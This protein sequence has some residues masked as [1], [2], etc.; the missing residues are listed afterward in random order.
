MATSP[1]PID[2]S[3]LNMST[4]SSI[5]G[6]ANSGF[7]AG[8]LAIT[9]DLYCL[10]YVVLPIIAGLIIVIAA[11]SIV[12]LKCDSEDLSEELP[13]ENAPTEAETA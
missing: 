13:N 2:Q 6:T 11:I 12:A 9:L 3:D 8:N 1:S 5:C 4:D 10:L 7:V